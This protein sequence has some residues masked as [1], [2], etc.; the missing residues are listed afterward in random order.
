LDIAF[1]GHKSM[2]TPHSVQL[3]ESEIFGFPFESG[4]KM[5]SGQTPMHTKPVHGGHFAWLMQILVFSLSM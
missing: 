1:V 3:A 2:H 5:P 4:S